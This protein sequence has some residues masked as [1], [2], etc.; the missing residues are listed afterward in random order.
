MSASGV[1]LRVSARGGWVALAL[2]LLL[3][4]CWGLWHRSAHG[5]ALLA[6][7][8]HAIDVAASTSPPPADGLGHEAG[9]AACQLLDHL[10]LGAFL[11]G[12]DVPPPTPDAWAFW[13]AGSR[14]TFWGQRL[15]LAYHARAPPHQG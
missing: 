11:P 9:D 8:A 10:L 4:Q 13:C 1:S 3:G 14:H 2:C 5:H 7:S 6:G 12:A 15:S